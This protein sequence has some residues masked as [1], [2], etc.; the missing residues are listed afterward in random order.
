MEFKLLSKAITEAYCKKILM[1][2]VATE[3]LADM[4]EKIKE[5]EKLFE[6]YNK[7]Y[8][9]YI[10]SGYWT[11]VWEPLKIDPYVEENFGKHASLFYLHAALE[12][13]PLTEQRYAER[14]ISS[15]IFVATLRDIGVWV[16]NAYNLVGYYCIRN[17]SWTWRHLE[18]KLFRLGRLQYMVRPFKDEVK[19]FYNAH[20]NKLLLLADNGMELRANGDMQGVCGKEKTDDGFVTK[21]EETEEYYI[22]NPITPYGKGIK[23]EVKLKKSE[24]KKVLDKGDHLLEIHI[25]RDGDFSLETVKASYAQAREF[26]SKHFPE[27]DIKG[28]ACHTWLFTRQLQDMLPQSSKIVQFQRQFYLYP[29]SGSVNFLWNFVY[30]DLTKKEDAK[31]DTY[32]RSQVLKFIDE[33]REIFDMRGVFLDAAG[34]FGNTSYMDKYDGEENSF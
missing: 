30:N 24:W 18:A 13:L 12:R 34:S 19:G 33:G 11:T 32:L 17:F 16:Q 6:I 4:A 1:P 5:D 15:E 22:G 10:N 27:L 20:E 26:Y 31:G 14:G 21:Y 25:P 28:M 8:E 9:D 29:T 23:E 7:F 2:E 3:I